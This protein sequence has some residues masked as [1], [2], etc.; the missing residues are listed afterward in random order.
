[1]LA[2]ATGA[3]SSPAAAWR[4][5]PEGVPARR[6]PSASAKGIHA[7]TIEDYEHGVGNH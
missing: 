7:R 4:S 1:M 2:I 6:L 5:W 3:D